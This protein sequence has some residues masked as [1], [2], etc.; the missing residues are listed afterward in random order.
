[1]TQKKRSFL[2]GALVL[3]LFL[4][5][6]AVLTTGRWHVLAQALE[7]ESA[8]PAASAPFTYQGQLANGSGPVDGD[9][10]MA[11]R[12]Y[13]S[14]GGGSQ[15]SSP[16]TQTVPVSGG[17][18]AVTLDFEDSALNGD[19]RWLGIQ[20]Q[21]PGD[22]AFTDLGRQP[23]LPTPYAQYA[24]RAPWSGLIGVPASL[25]DGDDDTTYTAGAG[26]TLDGTRFSVTTSTIQSRVDAS[27]TSGTAIRSINQ[28]GSVSCEP[29][30]DTTYTAGNGLVLNGTQFSAQGSP[31]ANVV[32]VAQAGGDYTSV[33][34]AIDSITDSSAEN[35]YLV[36]IAPG[37]YSETVI[38]KPYV[39]L[40][41]AG[42][43][44]TVISSTIGSDSV[45]AL[46]GTLVL[47]SNAS[48]R[49]L[50][51]ENGGALTHQIALLAR[52]GTTQTLVA[53][54]TARARASVDYASAIWL[55]G[56]DTDVTLQH[57][58]A[59]AEGEEWS[60]G[61]HCDYATVTLVGGLYTG[62]GGTNTIGI[63][64]VGGDLTASAVVA[65]GE[66]GYNNRGLV[67]AAGASTE[68]YG[69]SFTARGGTFGTGI[70]NTSASSLA[71]HDVTALA[72]G[73]GQNNRG[74]DNDS[75]AVI[76]GGSFTGRG[77]VTAYGIYNSGTSSLTIEGATI[78][79]TDGSTGNFGLHNHT[80]ASVTATQ[81]VLKGGTNSAEHTGSSA[82]I[83]NSR[84][85]GGPVSGSVTCVLVTRGSGAGSVSTD[86]STCP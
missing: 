19:D 26:L 75:D 49:D 8:A 48:L 60:H 21:C 83:S 2:I 55:S 6:G 71:A 20:V 36:W 13:D 63:N 50:T 62:Q 68:L 45:S 7:G 42:Q 4:A 73:A 52:D 78:W 30:D 58:T 51:L 16:V 67:S 33:Q 74:L 5:L 85:E 29:D 14:S 34:A 80:N 72:E 37:V 27:C 40:Q 81:C 82:T 56:S 47:T 84:L 57:V 77:G 12:L 41:G 64:N 3:G 86:G 53:N 1:M 65:L 22:S 9:C 35:T 69:G 23:L 38:M 28:D 32:I 54:V 46:Q 18:F 25:A 11:F 76:N 70:D 10:Q 24:H 43:D 15:V 17:L 44:V 31:Y 61:L 39:H 66:D 79:G 59:Q